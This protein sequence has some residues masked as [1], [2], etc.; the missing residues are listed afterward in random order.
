MLVIA[1]LV[2]LENTPQLDVVVCWINNYEKGDTYMQRI[3]TLL[4]VLDDSPKA[5][6]LVDPQ[7][8]KVYGGN[9]QAKFLFDTESSTLMLN[10]I[11]KSDTSD[12]SVEKF[13]EQL[14]KIEHIRLENLLITDKDGEEQECDV[15][16]GY[17]TDQK[18]LLFLIIKIKVDNRPL[19]M[20]I[21]LEKSKY[22]AIIVGYDEN[23]EY[24]VSDMN[25]SFCKAFACSPENFGERYENRH[26]K[27]LFADNWR[28]DDLRNMKS[29]VN[30]SNEGL[31][32]TS[33]KDYRGT[34]YSLYFN[35]TKIK[36]LLDEGDNRFFCKL[37]KKGTPIE[38]IECPYDK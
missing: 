4:H 34:Q 29:A 35:N 19:F 38:E 8:S 9:A 14:E 10:D 30:N 5:I 18:D 28:K 1:Q 27:L 2:V 25:E 22:P 31:I 3:L 6:C 32:V 12:Y 17:I 33:I 15:E 24:I 23:G 26:L 13:V 20:K 21:L 37:A 7:T 16:V 36:P 11:L